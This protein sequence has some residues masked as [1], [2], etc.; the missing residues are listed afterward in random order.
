MT[1]IDYTGAIVL[2]HSDKW[3]ITKFSEAWKPES[4]N[5][6]DFKDHPVYGPLEKEWKLADSIQVSDW[7]LTY[8]AGWEHGTFGELSYGDKGSIVVLFIP[9]KK[10]VPN[11][12]M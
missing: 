9:E 2:S 5:N 10:Y 3:L 11:K 7:K 4:T 6:I 8:K 12:N 1:K